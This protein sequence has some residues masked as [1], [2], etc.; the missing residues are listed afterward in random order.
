MRI[1]YVFRAVRTSGRCRGDSIEAFHE[2]GI[3]PCRLVRKPRPDASAGKWSFPQWPA[4]ANAVVGCR[5]R[6]PPRCRFFRSRET[7]ARSKTA[8]PSRMT[9][10]MRCSPQR[11]LRKSRLR[12]NPRRR[13]FAIRRPLPR[14][15]NGRTWLHLRRSTSQLRRAPPRP[16]R[17]PA[18]RRLLVLL[19]PQAT[20]SPAHRAVSLR[21][22]RRIRRRSP[23]RVRSNP[24]PPTSDRRRGR[25]W[26]LRRRRRRTRSIVPAA[27][28]SRFSSASAGENSGPRGANWAAPSNARVAP[29]E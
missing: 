17:G 11:R 4:A 19:P 2:L 26:L 8:L 23:R 20:R 13:R 7:H 27:Q 21:L 16:T 5:R 3:R 22:L 25:L 9:V 14:R 15:R 24:R 28:R 6:H 12:R 10:W 29:R 1:E 18:G